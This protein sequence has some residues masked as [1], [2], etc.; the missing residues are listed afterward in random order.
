MAPGKKERLRKLKNRQTS[1]FSEIHDNVPCFSE[2]TVPTVV[3]P[4]IEVVD[5]GSSLPVRLMRLSS[6]SIIIGGY[7]RTLQEAK[8][9]LHSTTKKLGDIFD[10]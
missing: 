4:I 7:R 8:L 3:S 6:L 1:D 9:K 2:F 5:P 10:F